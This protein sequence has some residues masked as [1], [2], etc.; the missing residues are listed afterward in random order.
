MTYKAIYIGVNNILYCFPINK[1]NP[2]DRFYFDTSNKDENNIISNLYIKT[3]SD[4]SRWN[5]YIVPRA[6]HKLSEIEYSIFI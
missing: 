2:T 3:M 4:R 5:N 1:I 6:I